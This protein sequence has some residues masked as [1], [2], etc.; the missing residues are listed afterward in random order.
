VSSALARTEVLRAVLLLG[1][2][3]VERAHEVLRKVSLL[4]L[5]DRLL[6]NAGS[7]APAHVRSLDAI[8]LATA[9][10]LREDLRVVM[11]YDTRVA[12]AALEL[13]MAVE[14]PA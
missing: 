3:Y 4:R 6:D 7:L 1:P 9:G 14:S 8:H 13:G 12:E 11:T 10:R 5:D 2:A